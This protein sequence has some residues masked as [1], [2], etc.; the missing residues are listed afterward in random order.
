MQ[1][2]RMREDL[3]HQ[4]LPSFRITRDGKPNTSIDRSPDSGYSIHPD[5][6]ESDLDADIN[7]LNQLTGNDQPLFHLDSF[8]IVR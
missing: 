8:H 5:L 6:K 2:M 3:L 7:K 1:K 4:V